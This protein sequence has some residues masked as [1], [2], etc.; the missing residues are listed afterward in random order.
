MIRKRGGF[1]ALRRLTAAPASAIS[2]LAAQ[3]VIW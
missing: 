1:K 3:A 2:A